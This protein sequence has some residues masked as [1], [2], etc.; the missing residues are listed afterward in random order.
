MYSQTPA[1]SRHPPLPV[2]AA[3]LCGIAPI[4]LAG[5]VEV[6]DVLKQSAASGGSRRSM[7]SLNAMVALQFAVSTTLLVAAGMLVRTYMH[8]QWSRPNFETTGL[9][10]A[11]LDLGQLQIERSVG[12]RMYQTVLD[13]L[14]T[15]PGLTDVSLTRDVPPRS[16]TTVSS[17]CGCGLPHCVNE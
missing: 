14:S 8:A 13:R 11:T 15:V 5:R 7:Q 4:R 17:L 6:V 10:A 9:I 3:V 12:I 1:S 2:V 16:S